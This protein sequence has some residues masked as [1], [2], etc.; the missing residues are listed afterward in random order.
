MENNCNRARTIDPFL[1]QYQPSELRIASEFLATWQPYLCRDLCHHCTEIISDRIRS[2]DAEIDNGKSECLNLDENEACS[3]LDIM[4]SQNINDKCDTNSRG[5]W[6][7]SAEISSLAS[8]KDGTNGCSEHNPKAST[9]GG[10][11]SDSPTP[12][13]S[14]A[15]MAQE[16]EL[17]EGEEQREL[18]EPMVDINISSG[19][20]RSSEVLEKPQLSREQ[21]E[22]IRFMNVK[23]QKDFICLEKIK[24]KICNILAGL[25]LHMGVFS[26]AEQKRIVDYVY[27]LQEMGKKRELKG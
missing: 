15:D 18:D 11:T 5:S 13:M 6:K 22:Y 24:G 7:D 10:L 14:W 21:R 17:E 23:R 4:E 1:L 20:L 16:D 12:R 25:E 3:S 8:W 9:T 2:L 26:S 27:E 19:E